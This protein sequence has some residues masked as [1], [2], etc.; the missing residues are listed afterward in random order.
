SP[1]GIG[2]LG[3]G[4]V[5]G[6][7]ID[8]WQLVDGAEVIAIASRDMD[9]AAAKAAEHN[10]GATP[11][12]DVESLLA[13]DRVDVVCICTPHALHCEQVIAGA[14][15]GKH[16]VIEK[17]VALNREDLGRML[18]AVED[19]EVFTSVC[20]ELHWIGSFITTR[21]LIDDGVIGT[22]FYG[23]AGYYHGITPE[24]PQFAWGH[25]TRDGGGSAFLTAGCHALDGLIHL[26][27]DRVTEVTA[28]ANHSATN[29]HGY[30][31]PPNV[32]A[33]LKFA[34][35]AIGKV[36]VSIE[37]HNPYHFPVIIQGDKGTIRDNAYSTVDLPEA[38]DWIEI[39]CP[40]PGSGDV[41]HHPYLG[42]FQAFAD[43]IAD[44]RDPHNNL[45]AAA[46][47]H[48]VCFAIDTSAENGGQPENVVATEPA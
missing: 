5:A 47:V 43:A 21:Q 3:T 24:S 12:G 2:I 6:A 44:G 20:F 16:L 19:A 1:L 35:G 22:P 41:A 10:V 37:C 34:S 29:P 42:Q 31:Y 4:S 15:A 26:M 7:H 28:I 9:R 45:T 14:A 23:E 36:G 32:Q 27:D 38:Q 30:E 8:N 33:L 11:Y 18:A 13:D 17:P 40:I 25:H 48:D 46:H 39:D